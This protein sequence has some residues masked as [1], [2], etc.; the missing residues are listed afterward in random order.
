MIEA[1][2]V[3]QPGTTCRVNNGEANYLLFT[4]GKAVEVSSELAGVLEK[5]PNFLVR[6]GSQL[7]AVVMKKIRKIKKEV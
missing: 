1:V 6:G 4:A 7:E 3:G 2:Y 5:D